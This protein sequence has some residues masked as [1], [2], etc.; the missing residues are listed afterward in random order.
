MIKEP[1]FTDSKLLEQDAWEDI[2]HSD[3][4]KYFVELMEAHEGAL[5]NQVLIA[6]RNGDFPKAQYYSARADECRKIIV[7][8]EGRL[9]ELKEK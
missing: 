6:V 2:I 8:A 4:W 5:E 7:L 3:G 1:E 9:A